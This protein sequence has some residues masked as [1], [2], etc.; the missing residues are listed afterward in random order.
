MPE[1]DEASGRQHEDES[2][3]RVIGV[4]GAT[5]IPG[6]GYLLNSNFW[7]YG[8]GAEALGAFMKLYWQRVPSATA[9][10]N[11]F[12]YAEAH[13]VP[14]N[15]A[16]LRVLEKCGFSYWDRL[17]KNFTYPMLGLR[18]TLVYRIARPV[19]CEGEKTEGV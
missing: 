1:G 9:S 4:V 6:I 8:Y 11:G 19:E 18:D 3:G 16:S 10:E 5:I 7:G 14:D 13:V 2:P 12:D 17:E 15:A